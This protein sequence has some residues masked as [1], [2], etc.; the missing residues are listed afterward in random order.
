MSRVATP[1]VLRLARR[2]DLSIA[3][4]N[5]EGGKTRRGLGEELWQHGEKLVGGREW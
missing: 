4:R 5:G 1:V 3:L 2:D